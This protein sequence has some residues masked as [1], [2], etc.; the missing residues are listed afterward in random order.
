MLHRLADASNIPREVLN[1]LK[2]PA[3]SLVQPLHI[4]FDL[5]TSISSEEKVLKEKKNRNF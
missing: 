3:S 1:V 5:I 4:M 2:R